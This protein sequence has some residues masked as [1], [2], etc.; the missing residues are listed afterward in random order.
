[1]AAASA[2]L[3]PP[4][5][6]VDSLTLLR[7]PAFLFSPDECKNLVCKVCN[8]VVHEPANLACGHFPCRPCISNAS[9]PECSDQIDDLPLTVHHA[10]HRAATCRLRMCPY[11][12][13]GCTVEPGTLAVMMTHLGDDCAYARDKHAGV[14]RRKKTPE[15]LSLLK[16]AFMRDSRL[17][18]EG[19]HQL[20]T[21]CG[22]SYD[23]AKRWFR[24]QRYIKSRTNKSDHGEKGKDSDDDDDEDENDSQ[25]NRP[26]AAT[27]VPISMQALEMAAASVVSIPPPHFCDVR[28]LGHHL[29]DMS[30][31]IDLLTSTVQ[32]LQQ[33]LLHSVR[34]RAASPTP[35][36]EAKRTKATHL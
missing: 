32:A 29:F 7:N 26:A 27:A 8:L 21:T 31:R 14:T 36:H 28:L 33:A 1:M 34:K 2:S 15:Q 10:L 30:K 13:Q 20:A 16:A 23:E 19:M 35:S 11:A 17:R 12:S 4:L 3:S 6:K 24:N 9:C 25:Q 18:K 22:L 5:A